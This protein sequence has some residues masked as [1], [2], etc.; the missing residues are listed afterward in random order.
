VGKREGVKRE[1]RTVGSR[2]LSY[3][4]YSALSSRIM[5]K[6]LAGDNTEGTRDLRHTMRPLKEVWMQVGLEKVDSHEEVSVKA[7]LDSGATEMFADKKFV[8]RNGFRLE[9]LER[10]VRIRNV[11]GTGNSRGLVTHEIKVN[12]YYQG[13]ME[14]MKLDVCDLG[15]TEVILG[16][17]WLAVHNPEI[18]WETG[19]VRMTRCPPLCG[20][21]KEKKEKQKLKEARRRESEEEAAIR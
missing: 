4:K 8:E 15:R 14:R 5:N 20:K 13:H 16:M 19:E 7:L 12:M 17:P 2:L 9:K 1:W 10:L 6:G 3:N 11:D 21:N 18:N